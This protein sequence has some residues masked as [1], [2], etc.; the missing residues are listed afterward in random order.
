MSGAIHPTSNIKTVYL[1][2]YL[3]TGLCLARVRSDRQ[4]SDRLDVSGAVRDRS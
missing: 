4:K 1:T 2:T 3:E